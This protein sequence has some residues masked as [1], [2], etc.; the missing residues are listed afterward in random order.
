V[1]TLN[2]GN[3]I[4]NDSLGTVYIGEGAWGAPLRKMRPANSYVKNQQ[5]VHGFHILQISRDSI[6]ITAVSFGNLE[7]VSQNPSDRSTLQL[8]ENLEI[9]K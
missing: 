3:I 6:Q 9:I 1:D 2:N 8:P 5:S 4:R 7:S